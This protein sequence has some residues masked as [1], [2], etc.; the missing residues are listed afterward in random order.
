MNLSQKEAAGSMKLKNGVRNIII[1][2]DWNLPLLSPKWLNDNIFDGTLP[3]KVEMSFNVENILISVKRIETPKIDIEISPQRIC[4]IP[5]KQDTEHFDFLIDKIIALLSKLPHTPVHVLG[6]NF[7]FTS[8]D[9]I[10]FENLINVKATEVLD[11]YENTYTQIVYQLS[12][13]KPKEGILNLKID[14]NKK[15]ELLTANFNY[16]FNTKEI[17]D[18]KEILQTGILD[19]MKDRSNKVIEL[20]QGKDKDE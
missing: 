10:W 1:T 12:L 9:Y 14:Y 11:N 19:E 8:K 3:E 4:F 18:I 2:G 17:S 20:L 6:I 7:I 5:K 16:S 15:T 13:E